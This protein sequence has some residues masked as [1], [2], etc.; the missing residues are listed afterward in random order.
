MSNRETRRAELR[1]L[2]RARRVAELPNRPLPEPSRRRRRIISIAG[3][4]LFGIALV[5]TTFAIVPP[6]V[7]IDPS[8]T[9]VARMKERGVIVERLDATAIDALATA[10]SAAE[11]L[12]KASNEVGGLTPA[13]ETVLITARDPNPTPGSEAAV[14]DRDPVYAYTF[15]AKPEAPIVFG[16]RR[17]LVVVIIVDPFTGSPLIGAGFVKQIP[18]ASPSPSPSASPSTTP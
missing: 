3:T 16:G 8:A 17:Y 2:P 5:L 13:V 10:K 12:E 18:L 14:Y 11:L 7:G 1:H 6:K 4:F 15:T 9:L